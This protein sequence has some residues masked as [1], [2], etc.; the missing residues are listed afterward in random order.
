[1]ELAGGHGSGFQS[2][3]NIEDFS[4]NMRARDCLRLF[5]ECW[6]T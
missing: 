5:G 2:L 1:L 6:A 4:P 3:R